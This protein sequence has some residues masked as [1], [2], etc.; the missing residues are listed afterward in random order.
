MSSSPSVTLS[1][2]LGLQNVTYS[3][4]IDISQAMSGKFLHQVAAHQLI[5]YWESLPDDP[6]IQK[7]IIDLSLR[8]QVIS[9]KT[10]FL[11][12]IPG[13][14]PTLNSLQF[15]ELSKVLKPA[16][17]R[18]LRRES[19]DPTTAFYD[20]KSR[21][22]GYAGSGYTFDLDDKEQDSKLMERKERLR[23]LALETI[24]LSKDPYMMRNHLGGPPPEPKKN[25]TFLDIIRKQTASGYW[26]LDMK[27]AEM[28]GIS[29]EKIFALKKHLALESSN[30]EIATLLALFTLQFKF[31]EDKEKWELSFEKSSTW[32]RKQGIED[33]QKILKDIQ[34]FIAK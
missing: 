14:N 31:L 28:V 27:L 29:L 8:Y 9:S 34:T 32:L 16:K 22:I 6:S 13:A 18:K 10:S 12:E 21:S 3:A 33:V 7:N 26:L 17:K 19:F 2:I 23:K 5:K 25:L 15:M 11:V 30:S 24:D 1:G 20:P 4:K